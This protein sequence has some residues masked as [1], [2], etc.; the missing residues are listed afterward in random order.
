MFGIP[1]SEL[2][3]G[4]IHP[5]APFPIKGVVWY[6]GEANAGK[7]EVYLGLLEAFV[8]SWR[9]TWNDPDLPFL[10]VQLPPFVGK[11]G[12][13]FTGVREA[14]MAASEKLPNV[15]TAVTLNTTDG[16]DLHP[17]EKRKSDSGLRFSR[18]STSTARRST[19]TA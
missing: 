4:K 5:L 14:Q 3:N 9:K 8:T 6:Q 17:P 2:Y 15:W 16:T 18:R 13:Y 12:H 7:P 1:A 11:M 19:P 10:I